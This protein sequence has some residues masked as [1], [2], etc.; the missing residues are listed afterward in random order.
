MID[1]TETFNPTPKMYPT[2]VRSLAPT[3][4]PHEESKKEKK[5]KKSKTVKRMLKGDVDT[6][7]FTGIL[8]NILTQS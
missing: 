8:L 5:D 1:F 3:K 2:A 6:V 7:D 4:A